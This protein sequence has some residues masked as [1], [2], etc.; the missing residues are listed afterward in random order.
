MKSNREN[1]GCLLNKAAAL[2]C[3]I[4]AFSL[5]GSLA[6]AAD[7]AENYDDWEP[8]VRESAVPSTQKTD[9]LPGFKEFSVAVRNLSS[10]VGSAS[11]KAEFYLNRAGKL[12]DYGLYQEAAKDLKTAAPLLPPGDHR[13][14]VSL[15]R[16]Y[17]CLHDY[18][19]TLW[20]AAKILAKNKNSPEGHALR[21][22]GHFDQP[23]R[24]IK[25][26]DRAILLS[27]DKAWFY[28]ARARINQGNNQGWKES[29]EDC[30]KALSLDKESLDARLFRARG[31]LQE[32]KYDQALADLNFILSREPLYFEAYHVRSAVHKKLNRIQFAKND[33]YLYRTCR[34]RMKQIVKENQS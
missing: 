19:Q 20:T 3:F 22:L 21:A 13:A 27:P 15:A 24:A 16:C 8:E 14:M 32:S 4:A 1:L 23:R 28:V 34:S 11:E 2:L 30:S 26:C 12:M 29:I 6:G 31:Y 25:E 33:D 5:P 10:P 7:R 9:P 17:F 18:S